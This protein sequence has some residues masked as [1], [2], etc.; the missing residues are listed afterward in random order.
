MVD[1]WT[2]A[3]KSCNGAHGNLLNCWRAGAPLGDATRPGVSRPLQSRRPEHRPSCE[4]VRHDR[5]R[6]PGGRT[7]QA[8]AASDLR[9]SVFHILKFHVLNSGYTVKR[10][11]HDIVRQDKREVAFVHVRFLKVA[12]LVACIDLPA[13]MEQM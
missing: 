10:R 4:S 1:K 6:G 2:N 7:S 8:A 5:S 13:V 12:K 11:W 3:E 9:L